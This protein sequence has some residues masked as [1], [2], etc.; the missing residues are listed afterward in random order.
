LT[1][2]ADPEAEGEK[3]FSGVLIIKSQNINRLLIKKCKYLPINIVIFYYH[4][5]S[6]GSCDPHSTLRGSASA[7]QSLLDTSQGK[8]PIGSR[9]DYIFTKIYIYI[10]EQFFSK[11]KERERKLKSFRLHVCSLLFSSC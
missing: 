7:F 1:I 4:S 10:V 11:K 9:S 6:V 5:F 2:H 8:S 3:N